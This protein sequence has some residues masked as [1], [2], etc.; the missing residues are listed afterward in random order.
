MHKFHIMHL[1]ES[2]GHL[3]LQALCKFILATALKNSIKQHQVLILFARAWN[4]RMYNLKLWT[5]LWKPVWRIGSH[6]HVLISWWSIMYWLITDAL[7][8][9]LSLRRKMLQE[10]LDCTRT[11]ES[12]GISNAFAINHVHIVYL[13][14]S[15]NAS[16]T[17]V[18]FLY[19]HR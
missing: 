8:R 1:W 16:V 5:L 6:T 19:M 14:V 11:T 10:T 13:F 9:M 7:I 4:V 12:F 2:Q 18:G 3:V 17:H 15:R